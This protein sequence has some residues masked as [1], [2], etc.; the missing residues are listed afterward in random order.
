MAFHSIRWSNGFVPS[1]ALS[2]SGEW[3]GHAGKYFTP[4]TVQMIQ[5]ALAGRFIYQ[6][7]CIT[8]P[9]NAVFHSTPQIVRLIRQHRYPARVRGFT[10]VL[11]RVQMKVKVYENISRVKI[12]SKTRL[13]TYFPLHST[14]ELFGLLGFYRYFQKVLDCSDIS[15]S[16]CLQGKALPTEVLQTRLYSSTPQLYRFTIIG[17]A[18][19]RL[20][21]LIW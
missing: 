9:S 3:T 12:N 5:T 8:Y 15:S 2:G 14:A 21:W 7:N 18:G 17:G 16:L 6:M 10:A 20:E 4:L 13:E 11:L 19:R 1:E